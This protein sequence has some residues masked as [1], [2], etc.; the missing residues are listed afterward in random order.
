MKL[1]V[2]QMYDWNCYAY[3]AEDVDRRYWSYFEKEL[4]WQFG[5]GFIKV[6][7][8]VKGFSYC[9][10]KFAKYGEISVNQMLRISPAPWKK[11]LN[12]AVLEMKKV[13]V[14]YFICGSTAMAL[15]GIEVKPR[16]INIV[17]PNYSDFDKVS[18]HFYK[19]AIQPFER[20]ENWVAS[21][22]GR[23]F[24]EAN[25]GFSFGNKA[26]KP[27]D[28]HQHHQLVYNGESVYVSTLEM[29]K[30]DNKCYSR[31][32]RARLIEEKMRQYGKI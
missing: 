31:P 1:Y 27:Y 10:E 5:N 4:W 9:A 8:N 32:E 14:D 19:L 30:H 21:G 29:L 26:L 25:I 28:M 22:L 15:W 12:F 18:E 23:I 20:C 13:G 11:A 3:Y 24:S 17:V 16:D 7:D 6:F 2:K